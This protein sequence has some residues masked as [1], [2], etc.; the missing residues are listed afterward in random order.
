VAQVVIS[1]NNADFAVG[2]FVQAYLPWK[3]YIVTNGKEGRIRKLPAG[4]PPSYALG[5]LGMP[6][7]TAY[8]GLLDS[9]VCA[10]KQGETVLVSGAAGAVGSI[11]GQIAKQKGCT[12]I[13]TAGGDDKVA[14]LK[15]LGFDHVIDYK[16]EKTADQVRAALTAVAPKGI[17]VYFDNTG[18]HVSDAAY[19]LL[20]KFARVAICGQISMYNSTE[21]PVVPAF[22]HKIIYKGVNIRGFVVSEFADRAAEF[23]GTMAPW[24]KSGQVK[25]KETILNG[26]N[27]VP[28]C[29]IGLFHGANTGKAVVQV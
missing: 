27:N 18:G 20:N 7:M 25:Y 28:K 5:V 12:V 2:D 21:V 16:K 4:I 26:F 14:F 24:V 15:T 3:K 17:D 22:L 13:G 8:F 11:V 9:K 29:F 6:G 1:K 19:D 23:F 10:L